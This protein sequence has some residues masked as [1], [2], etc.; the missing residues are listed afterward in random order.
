M[1]PF[2]RRRLDCRGGHDPQ[3]QG[4]RVFGAGH[5][6]QGLEDVVLALPADLLAGQKRLKHGKRL[7]EAGFR[8]VHRHIKPAGFKAEGPLAHPQ[9]TPT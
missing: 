8:L 3:H 9:E 4:D 2:G 6:G 5:D 7:V 1:I